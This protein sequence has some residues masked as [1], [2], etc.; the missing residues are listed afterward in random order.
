MS[1]A[2]YTG[3]VNVLGSTPLTSFSPKLTIRPEVEAFGPSGVV[4]QKRRPITVNL[5]TGVFEVP[6]FPSSE[7]RGS[8]GRDGV[9]YV[10]ELALFDDTFDESRRIVQHDVWVFTAIAGGGNIHEMGAP[11]P[12]ALIV[13]PPWPAVPRPGA[14]FDVTTGDVGFY[15]IGVG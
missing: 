2:I 13:G 11:P 8:D 3:N 10:L 15:G 9:K 5:D 12:N 4:S 6:L 7:L 1:T 14:Y